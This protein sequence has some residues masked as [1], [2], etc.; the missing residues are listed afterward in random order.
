MSAQKGKD[1]LVR[2]GNGSGGFVAVAGLRAR[3]IAFNA[4]TVDVTNA[5]S[6]GRWREL[7]AGAGVRRAAIS[8]SGVFRDEASDLRLRQLF[9]E[10]LIETFQIVVPSFGTL[11]GPFQIASLE[12]RGD[13]AGEV[14][15]DMSLDSAGALSFT[16]L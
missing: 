10:G 13:H 3:Q 7:L 14:T 12:Y 11:E 8:G 15:F 9:F 4:E 2:A 16:A 6:A 1:L 5:D